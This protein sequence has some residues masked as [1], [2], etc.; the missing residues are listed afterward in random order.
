MNREIE[1]IMALRENLDDAEK[2]Q[3][4]EAIDTIND[5]FKEM[6]T[7]A[8]GSILDGETKK[9]SC[10]A[11]KTALNTIKMYADRSGVDFPNFDTDEKVYAYI[12][13]Y[14]IE[15]VKTRK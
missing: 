7:S 11:A 14:G 15:I 2:K 3:L 12:L 4:G 13:K 1:K 10:E 6:I 5:T 8:G 9:I